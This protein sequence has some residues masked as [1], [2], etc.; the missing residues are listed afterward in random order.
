MAV[1]ATIYRCNLNIANMDRH[2]YDERSLTVAKHPSETDLRVMIRLITYV[3][4]ADEAL[5]FTRGIS[6]DEAP[7]L[8]QKSLTGDIELWIDIGQPDEKRIKKAS[9][10]SKKVMIYIYQE[11]AGAAWFRQNKK[12]LNRFSNIS[13]IYL[14][15]D[16]DLE[17]MASRS[18]NL[19]CN[20]SDGEL[21][22]MSDETTALVHCETWKEGL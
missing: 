12:V 11:G 19:Q 5:E 13:V 20:I 10:R 14:K 7:D 17:V 4:N 2:Y 16:G 22:V 3:L 21:T 9:G 15:V 1:G 8:W 18:M 6:D